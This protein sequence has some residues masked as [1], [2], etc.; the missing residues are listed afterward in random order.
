MLVPG[1]RGFA[2]VGDRL[3]QHPHYRHFAEELPFFS[4]QLEFIDLMGLPIREVRQRVAALPDHTAI[5]YIGINFDSEGTYVAADVLPLIAEVA[6]RPIIV[7]VD[8]FFGT[9]AVGGFMLVPAQ[10]GR[11]AGRLVLR[12]LNGESASSI[13]V[14]RDETRKPIF[15]WRQLQRWNI[16]ED[17]LPQ[18]SEVRFRRLSLWKQYRLHIFLSGV[19][20]LLQ[21]VLIFWLLYEHRRRH[22]AEVVTRNTMSELAQMNRLATAGELSASIAHEVS[23]P[24]TGIVTK[25]NAALRWLAADKPDVDKARAALAQ[26]VGA[27]HRASGIITNIRSML[28]KDAQEKAPVNVNKLIRGVLRLVRID[29]QKHQIEIETKLNRRIPFVLG[30]KV[31]LQQVILNLVMN[32]IESMHSVQPRVLRVKSERDESDGVHVS[33]EDTGA[34]IDP[35]NLDSVFKP[36]FTTKASGMGMGLSICRSII[37]S[38]D[39]R[40]WVSASVARG[41]VFHFSLPSLR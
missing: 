7:D 40:I 3:E 5:L 13:P 25:A 41:S 26:I 37:E 1:L 10:I 23:Q 14:T 11:D 34:G 8:T 32:A 35:S 19:V 29:L 33:I 31:Q 22:L 17:R 20:L 9:G 38:H 6:N 16:S 18:G 27:G 36:L 21:F 12:I 2:I 39:G 24:L 15:D 4:Q 30:N 28:K